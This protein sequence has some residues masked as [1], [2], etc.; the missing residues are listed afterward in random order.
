MLFTGGLENYMWGKKDFIYVLTQA[1]VCSLWV[2]SEGFVCVFTFLYV[3]V[4]V[5]VGAHVGSW[6]SSSLLSVTFVDFV[7]PPAT[8]GSL[9]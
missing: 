9:L 8:L 1:D 3:H 6:Y 4:Y 5:V 7:S 2:Y